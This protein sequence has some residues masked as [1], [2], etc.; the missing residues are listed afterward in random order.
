[1]HEQDQK[2]EDT[3]LF[4]SKLG[5]CFRD[6]EDNKSFRITSVVKKGLEK[7][8][9][10]RFYD[11]NEHPSGP[12]RICPFYDDVEE[13][14]FEYTHCVEI[15]NPKTEYVVWMDVD[16]PSLSKSAPVTSGPPVLSSSNSSS[17]SAPDRNAEVPSSTSDP[18]PSA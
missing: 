13:D 11:I 6:V 16:P 2:T 12:P 18:P 1:M 5:K 14:Q 17:T 4:F 15:L 10:Y 7:K 8:L 3:K 9:F